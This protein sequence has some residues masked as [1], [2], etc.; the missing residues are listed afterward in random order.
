MNIIRIFL[1]VA[2]FLFY[3][4]PE[5]SK[6]SLGGQCPSG[7]DRMWRGRISEGPYH[8]VSKAMGNHHSSV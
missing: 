2:F 6:V 4:Q 8:L 7:V 3:I 5:G 1:M